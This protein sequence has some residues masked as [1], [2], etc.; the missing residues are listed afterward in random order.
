MTNEEEALAWLVKAIEPPKALN[1][2]KPEVPE[3]KPETTKKTA[4][5]PDTEP[6]EKAAPEAEPVKPKASKKSAP[7]PDVTLQREAVADPRPQ[8]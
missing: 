2:K 7:K 5:K 3:K 1:L 6:V 4:P 8:G